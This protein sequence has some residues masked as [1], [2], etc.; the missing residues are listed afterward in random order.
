MQKQNNK[1]QE[2]QADIVYSILQE[3]EVGGAGTL[4]ALTDG[5]EVNPEIFGNYHYR[6]VFEVASDLY[7]KSGG[8][9]NLSKILSAVEQRYRTNGRASQA[10]ELMDKWR[11]Q[12][13]ET[14][15]TGDAI[16]S[17]ETLRTNY[18][19]DAFKDKTPEWVERVRT[20]ESPQAD[21]LTI[22]YEIAALAT[23]AGEKHPSMKDALEDARSLQPLSSGSPWLDRNVLWNKFVGKG[24]W[25][26]GK[27][28]TITAPSGHGK[29]SSA[30]T[31]AK[32]FIEEHNGIVIK[33][34]AEESREADALRVLAAFTGLIGGKIIN[35]TN[36]DVVLINSWSDRLE[37]HYFFYDVLGMKPGEINSIVR[38]HR[39]QNM[40]AP[41]LLILDHISALDNGMGNWS[42]ELE[43]VMKA[44]VGAIKQYNVAGVV[45]AQATIP[46]ETEL[47]E[48][49]YTNIRGCRGS[50]GVLQWSDVQIIMC[51]H[52]DEENRTIIQLQK[53]RWGDKQ[54][55]WGLFPFDPYVGLLQKNCVLDDFEMIIALAVDKERG[56]HV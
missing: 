14:I 54:E 32:W 10:D 3:A 55:A 25:T 8:K 21:V 48:K 30:V 35:P 34:S 53:A 11:K 17:A 41:M 24:G 40:G 38:R 33:L 56:Q 51:R 9:V 12:I 15:V 45:Y 29:S 22:S 43:Q 7:N 4:K 47:R 31:F 16:Q 2:L 39:L 36:E 28:V 23:S 44:L 46:Q 50:N 49:N 52:N 37:N 18:M 20:S 27:I 6:T 26:P 42:R 19:R 1:Y 13:K 5:L